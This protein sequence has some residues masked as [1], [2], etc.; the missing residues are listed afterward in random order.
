VKKEKNTRYAKVE[1][2]AVEK[3]LIITERSVFSEK[4]KKLLDT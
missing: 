2:M 4:G 1:V 3:R